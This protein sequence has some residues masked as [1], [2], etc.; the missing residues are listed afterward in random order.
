MCDLP[1]LSEMFLQS[2]ADLVADKDENSMFT[3]RK[4]REKDF[5]MK[6]ATVSLTEDFYFYLNTT[7]P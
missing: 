5:T 7:C 1:F 2:E 4:Q 3:I 6:K